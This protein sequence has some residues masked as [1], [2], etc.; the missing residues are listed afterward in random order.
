MD[1]DAVV[2]VSQETRNDVLR[3]FPGVDPNKVRVIHNGIDLSEYRKT[4]AVDALVKRG[5]DPERPFVL[6]SAALLA[7]R[8]SFTS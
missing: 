4:N 7:R 6:S 3:C 2:A 1:A 8:A 5:V